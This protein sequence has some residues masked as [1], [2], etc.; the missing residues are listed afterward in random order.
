VRDAS[1]SF[2]LFLETLDQRICAG[3]FN[4]KHIVFLLGVHLSLSF[5]YNH[6]LAVLLK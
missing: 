3:R 2:V 4:V 1:L 6:L 5:E